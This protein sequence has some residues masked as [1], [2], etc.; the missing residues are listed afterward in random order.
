MGGGARAAAAGVKTASPVSI[1]R[2]RVADVDAIH[3]IELASFSD[4]WS[5]V[6]FRDSILG[7]R[8][9]IVVA[10]DGAQAVVGFAM[11]IAAAD[12]AEVANLAVVK[13][14]RRRGV[15]AALLDHLMTAAKSGGAATLHLEVRAS[16]TAAQALYASRGFAEVSR[17]KAYYERPVE[18]AVVMRLVLQ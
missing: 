17:R 13:A 6:S 3:A 1:R 7:D 2:A 5:R 12:E 16:N 15:G 14:E 18:D 11:L 4:P 10:F 8:G 9:L